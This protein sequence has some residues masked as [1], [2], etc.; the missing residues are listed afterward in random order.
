M[1]LPTAGPAEAGIVCSVSFCSY[2]LC[3]YPCKVMSIIWYAQGKD[4]ET[5]KG[6]VAVFLKLKY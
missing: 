1:S 3:F 6:G 2:L 4:E 5:V